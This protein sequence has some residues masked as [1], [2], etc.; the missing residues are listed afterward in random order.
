[1]SSV[2]T[3]RLT[4]YL[5]ILTIVSKMPLK[6]GAIGGSTFSFTIVMAVSTTPAPQQAIAIHKLETSNKEEFV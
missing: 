3:V 2:V 6:F 1:M 4:T 5:I